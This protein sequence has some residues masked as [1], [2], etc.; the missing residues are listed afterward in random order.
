MK[1]M[2]LMHADLSVAISQRLA[3]FYKVDDTLPALAASFK[4]KNIENE[5]IMNDIVGGRGISD[6]YIKL[7]QAIM[8]VKAN[9][10]ADF[11][12]YVEAMTEVEST[13][14]TVKMLEDK[15]AEGKAAKGK[16]GGDDASKGATTAMK[17]V[18][19]E[20]WQKTDILSL[21]LVS[22]KA[23]EDMKDEYNSATLTYVISRIANHID[24]KEFHETVFSSMLIGDGS[25]N[26]PFNN[27]WKLSMDKMLNYTEVLS[28]L[29]PNH[30]QEFGFREMFTL[31]APSNDVTKQGNP[32]GVKFAGDIIKHMTT[33]ECLY[34][35]EKVVNHF[36]PTPMANKEKTVINK[37]M[38]QMLE[39]VN[40]MED[41][42]SI[43]LFNCLQAWVA[44]T[45]RTII[46][47]QRPEAMD[48]VKKLFT[49]FANNYD[50]DG[51]INEFLG[52]P[53]GTFTNSMINNAEDVV[54]VTVN[55][56]QTTALM[57]PYSDLLPEDGL[58]HYAST[59]RSMVQTLYPLLKNVELWRLYRKG[60]QLVGAATPTF[61]RVTRSLDALPVSYVSFGSF[62]GNRIQTFDDVNWSMMFDWGVNKFNSSSRTDII[63]NS[64]PDD[65]LIIQYSHGTIDYQKYANEVKDKL[66]FI[67]GNG[68]SGFEFAGKNIPLLAVRRRM[69]KT[70]MPFI[71]ID[72]SIMKRGATCLLPVP[73]LNTSAIVQQAKTSF[74]DKEVIGTYETNIDKLPLNFVH[75]APIKG[76]PVEVHKSILPEFLKINQTNFDRALNG[77]NNGT[78]LLRRFLNKTAA[79]KGM[80]NCTT[81]SEDPFFVSMV[82]HFFVSPTNWI[83]P[84]MHELIL[85]P[86]IRLDEGQEE[87]GAVMSKEVGVHTFI[88][89]QGVFD[90]GAVGTRILT[91]CTAIDR[92][93]TLPKSSKIGYINPEY[94]TIED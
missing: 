4:P 40:Q 46:P 12:T 81:I 49:N 9:L 28:A 87:M 47:Y 37:E 60:A 31:L 63:W 16:A 65:E 44:M 62:A 32:G 92:T 11:A 38:S 84:K 88:T 19:D 51:V 21:I 25:T 94:G 80:I 64:A 69:L 10:G 54:S 36:V 79:G 72:L 2:L 86:F 20:I 57:V 18:I 56:S 30:G 26:E 77:K 45:Q 67:A 68:S 23:S 13:L 24:P 89:G 41:L 85:R 48:Y 53:I 75:T 35:V 58:D 50:M 93:D 61:K 15:W 74:I 6:S 22:K 1:K 76:T 90:K 55:G 3:L 27:T 66:T 71:E 83:R 34:Q 7:F 8:P 39:E 52:L 43:R 78:T 73:P 29:P 42:L 59:V 5:G 33:L 82:S 17:K 14:L 91:S 70:S